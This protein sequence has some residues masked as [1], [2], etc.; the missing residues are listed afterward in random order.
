MLRNSQ[1]F[2]KAPPEDSVLAILTSLLSH[3]KAPPSK[4]AR[5]GTELTR[6]HQEDNVKYGPWV[7]WPLSFVIQRKLWARACLQ[8]HMRGYV[9]RNGC[10]FSSSSVE[11]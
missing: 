2:Q 3:P 1:K 4:K 8:G 10:H 7:K 6:D 9:D 5:A 11:G